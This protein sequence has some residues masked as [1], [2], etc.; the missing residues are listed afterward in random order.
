MSEKYFFETIE[1]L[2]IR[3]RYLDEPGIE[4][5][6][7]DTSD[8]ITVLQSEELF[9]MLTQDWILHFYDHFHPQLTDPGAYVA[10]RKLSDRFAYQ[11]GNHGWHSDWKSTSLSRISRYLKKNWLF[12]ECDQKVYNNCVFLE[13][14]PYIRASSG[15]WAISSTQREYF[16][17]HQLH[18]QA[19]Q[20]NKHR[21]YEVNGSFVLSV[22]MSKTESISFYLDDEQESRYLSLGGGYLS[23]L[24]DEIR[25]TPYT[26][27]ESIV[28]I[29]L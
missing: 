22:F 16:F 21:L 7:I 8:K 15:F 25:L 14:L 4:K 12:N 23:V 1:W 13:N 18:L 17:E 2:C 26:F 20:E 28:D 24:V 19:A 5:F 10:V 27:S 9:K 29:R 6:Y 11:L 3:E